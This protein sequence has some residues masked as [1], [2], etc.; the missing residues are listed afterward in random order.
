MQLPVHFP[1]AA[2]AL[3]LI[4]SIDITKGQQNCEC[5][6]LRSSM[7]KCSALWIRVSR[8]TQAHETA[9]NLC[10][11]AL[12]LPN[13]TRW[14]SL[15][16]ALLC[17]LEID[18]RLLDATFDDLSLPRLTVN[19]GRILS[20]YCKVLGLLARARDILQNEE[21]ISWFVY[22]IYFNK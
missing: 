1:C 11:R 2:D 17:L 21:R 9:T 5:T 15:F 16:N 20:E 4:A 14:S 22:Q 19:E 6:H 12:T 8:S 10:G 7:A 3:N 13:D 18:S